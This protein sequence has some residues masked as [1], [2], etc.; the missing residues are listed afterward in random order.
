MSG[1][2]PNMTIWH[3]RMSI[4]RLLAMSLPDLIGQSVID[5]RVR[6]AASHK[7]GNDTEADTRM[8]ETVCQK[9]AAF[10]HS[11]SCKSSSM[12]HTFQI[13]FIYKVRKKAVLNEHGH[14]NRK[15]C[16]FS[17]FFNIIITEYIGF[18]NIIVRICKNIL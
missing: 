8:T 12:L 4:A 18:F 3:R 15:V 10:Y 9:R 14:I 1:A 11:S 7:H 13:N 5:S 6:S 16:N 2:S 17:G